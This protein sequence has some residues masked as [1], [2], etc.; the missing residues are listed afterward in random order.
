MSRR[1]KPAPPRWKKLLRIGQ[2][3]QEPGMSLRSWRAILNKYQ[4]GD[5]WA[6]VPDATLDAIIAEINQTSEVSKTSEV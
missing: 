2:G 5:S 4:I 3:H 1:R 6:G